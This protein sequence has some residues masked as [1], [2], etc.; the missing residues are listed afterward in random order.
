MHAYICM[1]HRDTPHHL[2]N[3]RVQQGLLSEQ[4]NLIITHAITKQQQEQTQKQM[5]QTIPED[6]DVET[7]EEAD[8]TMVDHEF[9]K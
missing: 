6:V 9:G 1:A 7:I 4:A 5:H 2:K 3:K 8:T